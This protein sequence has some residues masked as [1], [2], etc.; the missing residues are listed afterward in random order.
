MKNKKRLSRTLVELIFSLLSSI[1]KL[2]WKEI[3]SREDLPTKD[4]LFEYCVNGTN[5]SREGVQL[6][7]AKTLEK[8]FNDN[9]N[10]EL[11]LTHYKRVK[12][13]RNLL[14]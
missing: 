9:I 4:G 8:L 12:F 14:W 10:E 6:V 13:L 7:N 1:G 5:F 11:K 2:G 3:N